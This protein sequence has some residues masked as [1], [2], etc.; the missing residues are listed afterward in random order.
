[1]NGT[2]LRLL[3]DIGLR[4]PSDPDP[5]SFVDKMIETMRK[6]YPVPPANSG[7]HEK[8]FIHQY[9]KNTDSVCSVVFVRHD[10]YRKSPRRTYN[11]PFGVISRSEKSFVFDIKGKNTII[12]VDRLKPAFLCSVLEDALAAKETLQQPNKVEHYKKNPEEITKSGRTVYFP[13][14]FWV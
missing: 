6:L 4:Q 1:M 7:C 3:G 11:G 2:T 5:K 13:I 10:A 12:C 14:R 8:P 9:L